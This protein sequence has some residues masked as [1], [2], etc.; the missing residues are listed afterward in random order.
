MIW[1]ESKARLAQLKSVI[2]YWL[3]VPINFLVAGVLTFCLNWL[4]AIPWRKAPAAHWTERARLLWPVRVTGATNILLMPVCLSVV[5][6]AAGRESWVG[7]LLPA[8]AG[9]AGAIL[10]TFPLDRQIFPR[11]TF[12]AWLRL[13]TVSWLL[14]LGWLGVLVAAALC[15]PDEFGV[16]TVVLG[17]GVFLYILAL[18]YGLYVRFLRG[19]GVLRQP[20]ERLR[21][22][23][24]ET[25]RRMGVHEPGT[26]LMDVP[27]AQAFALPTTGELMFSS[28][29]LEISSDEEISAICAHELA[30]L[31]ESKVV[32]TGRIAGS[33]ALYPFIFLRPAANFGPSGV[34]VIVGL[35][36]LTSTLTRK[37]SRR[38]E[39]RADKIAT[40]NQGAEGV[41][42]R[43]LERL[44][45]DTLIPAVSTGKTK[46]HA[47]LYDRMLAAGIQPEYP[48]PA[49]PK[50]LPWFVFLIY[51][52]FGILI[53]I[54]L[55]SR[56]QS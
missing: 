21:G 5:E 49:T 50:K 14:R 51:V 30:H 18:N 16:A 34:C 56:R 44:Y 35:G 4:S 28:R 3:L 23:V 53:G 2:G 1:L 46:T 25:A 55:A 54:A 48:R 40:E 22:I 41:Y 45:V 11:F 37:L 19:L 24:A 39:H 8:V 36:L 6:V 26:W 29:L 13:V 27:L 38:M 17:V 20:D 9:M 47:H 52:A 31:M 7:F 32:L 10:A 12:R 42:A 33:M 43:A 15:M